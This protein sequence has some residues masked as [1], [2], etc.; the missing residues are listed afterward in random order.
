MQKHGQARLRLHLCSMTQ[1]S[2]LWQGT[3]RSETA[4]CHKLRLA[5]KFT[6]PHKKA[7]RTRLADV[8]ARGRDSLPS[9]KGERKEN[10]RKY[11]VKVWKNKHENGLHA[12]SATMKA[13]STEILRREKKQSR[14][15]WLPL[16]QPLHNFW[17]VLLPN[18]HFLQA[19]RLPLQ[20]SRQQRS[21]QPLLPPACH[22]SGRE[23]LQT[24]SLQQ[25]RPQQWG[26]R[27]RGML[28][29]RRTGT[30]HG[31]HLPSSQACPSHSFR[32]RSTRSLARTPP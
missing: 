19:Q 29:S 25:L 4:C 21:F 11:T 30:W 16:P 8:N 17:R 14:Q 12:V 23:L 7:D 5:N 1:R 9:K 22:H 24:R 31:C 3:G 10:R 32:P 28:L 13:D 2:S 18:A 26:T 27:P 15:L 20:A 6:I